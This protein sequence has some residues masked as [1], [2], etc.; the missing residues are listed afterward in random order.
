MPSL[1]RSVR[2]A[3]KSQQ[4]TDNSRRSSTDNRTFSSVSAADARPDSPVP[5]VPSAAR[6][7]PCKRKIN[8]DAESE[9]RPPKRECS[10]NVVNPSSSDIDPSLITLL[11]QLHFAR[12]NDH[13]RAL[14]ES[15]MWIREQSAALV[16][17]CDSLTELLR[18]HSAPAS[19]SS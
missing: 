5:S 14:S 3:E 18:I 9:N 13:Y 6:R 10:D 2:L 1:R 8:F 16:A 12:K 19:C 4:Q 15:S 17:K 11:N 7:N